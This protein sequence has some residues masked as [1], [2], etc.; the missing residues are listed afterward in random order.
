MLTP[1]TDALV[2]ALRAI[3][4][5]TD[6]DDPDSYRAD[7]REGC[8]DTVQDTARA[9]LAAWDAAPAGWRAIEEAPLDR[10]IL[11]YREGRIYV[12]QWQPF[13]RTWGVSAARIPGQEQPFIDIGKQ[14]FESL[15][16]ASGPTHFMP[17]PA[18]PVDQ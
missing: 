2:A 16:A 6:P 12:A 15:I 4:Q 8:L 18:P 7:D 13:W 11:V 9:A 10:A 3:A 17:L 5:M 1:P 14:G